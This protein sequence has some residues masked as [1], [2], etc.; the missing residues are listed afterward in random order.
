[1]NRGITGAIVNRQ[2]FGGW[3]RSSVGPTSKAGGFNY[4]N[5]LRDWKGL[6]S[7]SEVITSSQLWWD[8]IGSKSIDRSGLKV[9]RNYQRY[10]PSHRGILIRLDG[11]LR[12]E[13]IRYLRW[14]VEVTKSSIM[15]STESA[16]ERV[17]EARI[18]SAGELVARLHGIDKVRWLSQEVPPSL[19]LLGKGISVDSRK[20]ASRGDVEMPRWL[21][22]QSVSITNH[23]YG[24]IGAG[25]VPQ[26][27]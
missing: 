13:V 3:K 23:R 9:E 26:L 4:V 5:N 12:D 7:A 10:R 20:V 25:P 16:D 8:E 24:N 18:E 11:A 21:L 1:M 22:E 6:V 19:E 14:V 17:A 2:P 15:W 27:P